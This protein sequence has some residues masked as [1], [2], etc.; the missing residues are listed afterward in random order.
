MIDKFHVLWLWVDGHA[1]P[2]HHYT[3]SVLG[4]DWGYWWLNPPMFDVELQMKLLCSVVWEAPDSSYVA[5]C[6]TERRFYLDP[7]LG[8]H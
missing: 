5:M 4:A 2:Y 1:E 7:T 8:T 3:T 6:H